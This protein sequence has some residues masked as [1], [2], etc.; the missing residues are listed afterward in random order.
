MVDGD[1]LGAYEIFRAVR[2][3]LVEGV[4]FGLVLA[5]ELR[6]LPLKFRHAGDRVGVDDLLLSTFNSAPVLTFAGLLPGFL[7]LKAALNHQA[8]EVQNHCLDGTLPLSL[9]FYLKIVPD[10]FSAA[11]AFLAHFRHEAPLGS[12]RSPHLRLVGPKDLFELPLRHLRLDPGVVG[13]G[14]LNEVAVKRLIVLH[15]VRYVL[16]SFVSGALNLGIHSVALFLHSGVSNDLC[17]G[18][19]S[20]FWARCRGLCQVGDMNHLIELSRVIRS[21]VV[22]VSV[23]AMGITGCRRN[24]GGNFLGAHGHGQGQGGDDEGFHLLRG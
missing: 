13:V 16:G 4:D 24:G 2:A 12:C 6:D 23:V 14:L 3:D 11:F 19:L 8:V 9:D 21:F 7:E 15:A 18:R 5:L 20:R 22:R 17:I 1:F 10:L